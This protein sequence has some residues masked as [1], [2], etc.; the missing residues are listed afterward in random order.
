[1]GLI[2]WL[3]S[4]FER[5]V[6]RR[7]V[8]RPDGDRIL[9]VPS[10]ENVR[11]LGGYPALS[12][13]T[14]SARYLRSGSTERLDE[15]DIRRL[16]R[17]G[18]THVLDLRGS[19]EAPERTCRYAQR[20]DTTWLNVPLF[21]YDLSDPKLSHAA[22]RDDFH[23]YLIGSYLDM[24]ANHEA[25]RQIID[26]LAWVPEGECALFHCAAGMDRTGVTAMLLLGSVG[27]RRQ[28][29]IADYTY[30]FGSIAEVDR[31]VADPD[32]DGENVWNSIHGRMN[33]MTVV[34][35]TLVKAYGSVDEYLLACGVTQETL[36]TLYERFVDV[37]SPS[38]NAQ[39]TCQ[40]NEA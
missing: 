19:F 24:L 3:K 27:V 35:D 1:M 33:T 37:T 34:Y 29:I 7:S 32:Y 10:G 11:E 9:D 20:H 13:V 14:K 2:D 23:D 39:A 18:V 4:L 12:G 6:A 26:F 21:G 5:P 16:A 8:L 17:Y 30:S 31:A 40:S 25:I 15:Q 28:Q 22:Q 36:D 38:K